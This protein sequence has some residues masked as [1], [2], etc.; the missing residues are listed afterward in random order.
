METCVHLP[1]NYNPAKTYPLIIALHGAG[2]TG[3]N[4][5]AAWVKGDTNWSATVRSNCIVVAPTWTPARW[6]LWPQGKDI[7]T[8]LEDIKSKYSVDTNMVLLNGFSNGAHSAWSLG[9]KQPSLFTALGPA[10]GLPIREAGNGLDLAMVA[11][12]VNLPVHLVHSGGD[13]ICPSASVQQVLAK[14]KKLG[15]KNIV[16][17]EYSSNKHEAHRVYWGAIFDWFTKLKR[18]MYPKKLVFVSDHQ[19]LDTA[20]WV[21]LGGITARAKVTAEV[22]GSTIKLKVENANKATIFLHDSM[23]NLDKPLKVEVNGKK[24]FSGLVKRSP[25]TAVQEALRRNDRN[26]VYAASVEVEVP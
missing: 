18:D 12:L 24:K 2:G 8:M 17:K 25:R 16:H 9:M 19:E 23:L 5:R 21:R 15:Y 13:R 7:Y 20:Y 4:L 14:Y 10:A 3:Q 6:W 26:A 1:A 11:S 22:K